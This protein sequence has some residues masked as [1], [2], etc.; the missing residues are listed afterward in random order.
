MAVALAGVVEK[1]AVGLE[2]GAVRPMPSEVV[3]EVLES[4][5]LV[6]VLLEWLWVALAG[7]LV[8]SWVQLVLLHQGLDL[9]ELPSGLQFRVSLCSTAS[10]SGSVMRFTPS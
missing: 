6:Q 1:E 9:G 7:L 10:A 4:L 3:V 2:L 8:E 5:L